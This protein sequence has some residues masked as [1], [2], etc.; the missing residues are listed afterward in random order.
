M[1][2]GWLLD[3]STV[4]RFAPDR[5]G[6]SAE[7]AEWMRRQ[8]DRLFMPAVAI[9]EIEAGICK[10][11]RS[12]GAARAKALLLWLEG[13][14]R[15]Y[16]D[17]VLAF[18]TAAARRAGAL[19]DAASA[20]ARNPGFADVAIA[21]VAAVHDLEILTQN[22]RHFVPLGVAAHDIFTTLPAELP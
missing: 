22:I 5:P 16:D 9:A 21:A 10:L 4:S 8:S 15:H 18:D 7:I 1:S 14:I 20:I 6:V 17:R 3:T 11:R 2:R 13:L 12:G 19:S